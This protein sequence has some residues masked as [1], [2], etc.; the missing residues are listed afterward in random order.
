[1]K[2]LNNLTIKNLKLNK[3]RTIVTIIGIILSTALMVGIGLLFSSFQDYMIREI[4]E[5][6]GS[7]HALY[8]DISSDKLAVI[9]KENLS[10]FYE[11][12]LGFAKIASQNE[13]KP[14]IYIDS[15]SNS[16]FNELTLVE[17]SFPQNSSE[18]VLS[19]HL[20][21]NGGVNYKVGDTI[22]L[23]YGYRIFEGDEI[24]ENIMYTEGEELVITSSNTYKIVGITERSNYEDYSAAGYT[25]FTLNDNVKENV[26]LYVTFNKTSKIMKQSAALA[27]KIDYNENYIDYNYSLLALY[28]ESGYGNIMSSMISMLVIM[29]ALVSI[30]C[31]I[32]IYNSFAISVM[33]RKKEFGLLSSIGATKKQL[34]YMIF[35]EAII[36]G[37]IGIILGV[38]GAYLGIGT[39]I[40]VLN[41]LLKG[42]L[43]YSLHLVTIP[44]F[45]IIPVIFMIVVILVSALIPSRRAS[46]VSPIEAIRQNDDI[47][48]NKKK[49]RTNPLIIKLFGI[50]GEIALKNIKRNKKKYRVTTVSLFISIVLFISFSAYMNYTLNTADS[51]LTTFNYDI[52]VYV[53]DGN[54]EIDAKVNQIINHPDTKDY[55]KYKAIDIPILRT[56]SYTND[57]LKYSKERFGDSYNEIFNDS[58]YDYISVI[59]LDDASYNKY[60][61]DIGLTED[62]VI[63]LNSFEGVTYSDGKRVGYDINV[64]KDDNVKLTLCDFS[65]LDDEPSNLNDYC[66][67]NLNNIFIT[68]K[69]YYLADELKQ[70]NGY[71]LIV[72]QRI[73]DTIIGKD[74]NYYI[75][76]IASNNYENLDKIG[77]EINKMN[78]VYYTNI[79]ENTKMQNNVTLALKILMY[80]FIS[81]VTLIGVTSVFNTISTSIALRKKEFAVLR[82]IGLTR[83]GFNKMLF[84]ESLFFGLK[85]LVFALPASFAI[86]FLIHFSLADMLSISTILIPWNSI[87]LAVIMVFVIVLITM[88]YSSSKIKKQNIIDQIREENI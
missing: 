32:V 42:V 4:K 16:F 68:D 13:D 51:L 35:F 81:L 21:S 63:L 48:I 30:G 50:E 87:L 40:I 23:N 64:I 62:K 86:I 72:N 74:T 7:Y 41:N 78:G 9:Q 83:G 71:K 69:N 12:G 15:V 6:N 14:Y 85:S 88:M 36:V 26:N 80:G 44:M 18:I 28:G 29:L 65:S 77:E 33:E 5:S 82:S 67:K 37:T 43:E 61:K 53:Y 79:A 55:V 31:I 49:I 27:S 19:S 20:S 2:I 39:V 3:K 58:K 59:I 84:F 60:K 52:N 45:I 24:H 57:Y 25:A 54:S 73:Y 70:I 46:R 11:S 34:S 10:Y 22:T 17:G 47:K 1:M 38:A 66:K 75:V 56:I 76:N 8:K